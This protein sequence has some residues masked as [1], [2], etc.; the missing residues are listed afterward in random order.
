MSYS[1][2]T[3][4]QDKISQEIIDCVGKMVYKEGTT[5]ISVRSVLKELNITN[6]VFYN[7]F[8]N[9]DEVLLIISQK[10]VKEMRQSILTPYDEKHNYHQYIISIATNVLIKTYEVKNNFSDYM[11]ISDILNKVNKEWWVEHIVVILNYGV[12]NGFLKPVNTEDISY[13]IWCFCRG[14]NVDAIKGQLELKDALKI[15]TVAFTAFIDGLTL[16]K[17]PRPLLKIKGKNI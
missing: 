2:G 7:R 4:L 1:Q 11:F 14:F 6:R 17:D 16:N 3:K 13:A 10:I 12:K 5:G 9:I 8:R 15:F